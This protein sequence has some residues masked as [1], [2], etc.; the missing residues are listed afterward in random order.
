MDFFG[1]KLFYLEIDPELRMTRLK[2]KSYCSEL[3]NIESLSFFL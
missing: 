3:Y 2:W 1:K